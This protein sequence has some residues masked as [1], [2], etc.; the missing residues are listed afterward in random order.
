[1]GDKYPSILT[2]SNANP[3]PGSYSHPSLPNLSKSK[4]VK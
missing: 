4:N 1:M 3:G 2:N